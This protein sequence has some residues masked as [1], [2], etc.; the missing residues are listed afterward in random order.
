MGK[1]RTKGSTGRKGKGGP[2]FVK[3]TI[4]PVDQRLKE[5]QAKLERK[6]AR[7]EKARAP[8]VVEA[9]PSALF[10][11]HNT[12]LGP[13]YH[14]IIDTNFINMCI[15]NKIEIVAGL[16]ACLYAK[17]IPVILDSVAAELEKLGS[18]YRVALR[19]SK[20]PRFLRMRGY[21]ERGTYADDDIVA[22]VKQHRCYMVA[23]CDKELRRRLRK[24]PGV[25]ICHIAGHKITVERLP[26]AFGAPR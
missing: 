11:A 10:F 15:R 3:R 9:T 25:P 13:P 17:A 5:G 6:R 18:K 19:M 20:D 26:E 22:T 12:N 24:V 1:A 23:T 7:A 21:A 8:R 4:N 2:A 16:Q 14:V